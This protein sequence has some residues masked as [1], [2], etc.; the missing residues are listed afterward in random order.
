MRTAIPLA[1]AGVLLVGCAFGE[2]RGYGTVDGTLVVTLKSDAFEASSGAAG[3]LTLVTVTVQQLQMEADHALKGG[4]EHV[5]TVIPIPASWSPLAGAQTVNFG[6][7]E[8]DGADYHQLILVVQ[9]L[10]LHGTIGDKPFELTIAP[11]GGIPIEAPADLPVNR[12][13]APNIH[14]VA[15]LEVPE[16][17]LAGTDPVADPAAASLAAAAALSSRGILRVDWERTP[18]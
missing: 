3:K 4:T 17:L 11:E 12:E 9:T 2:G 10:E 1:L 13:K 15:S 14:F 5:S 18:D 6:P 16:D 8:I 7:L